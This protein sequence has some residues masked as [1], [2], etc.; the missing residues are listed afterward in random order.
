MKNST[1]TRIGPLALALIFIPE[2]VTTAV[3]I[4][5]LGYSRVR[6][7][8]QQQQDIACTRLKRTFDGFYGYKIQMTGKDSIAFQT[9]TTRQGQL[10]LTWP[11]ITKVYHT[12]Q[13]WESCRS[14]AG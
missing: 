11:N 4:G 9:F 1:H 8:L 6:N 3:G 10:P 12:P 2:P 7:M 14:S 5:L 13:V